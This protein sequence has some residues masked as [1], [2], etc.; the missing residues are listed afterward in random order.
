MEK[1]DFLKPTI[2]SQMIEFTV[3]RGAPV[4]KWVKRWPT[5]LAV[6]GSS[7]SRGKIFSTVKWSHCTQP[8]IINRPST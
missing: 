4:A 3:M 8:F 6:P 5:D 7:T 1:Y 2:H